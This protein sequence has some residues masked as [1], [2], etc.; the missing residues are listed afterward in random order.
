MNPQDVL[1]AAAF[2]YQDLQTSQ[3]HH[4]YNMKQIHLHKRD[5]IQVNLVNTV[6]KLIHI[7]VLKI[8]TSIDGP[9]HVVKDLITRHPDFTDDSFTENTKN[10]TAYSLV[11]NKV[12]KIPYNQIVGFEMYLGDKVFTSDV[13]RS[14][15]TS[16][17]W[18]NHKTWCDKQKQILKSRISRISGHFD[19]IITNIKNAESQGFEKVDA[20]VINTEIMIFKNVM[21]MPSKLKDALPDDIQSVSINTFVKKLEQYKVHYATREFY[22]EQYGVKIQLPQ[23]F[24]TQEFITEYKRIIGVYIAK[25]QRDMDRE[26]KQAKADNDEDS[27]EEIKAIKQMLLEVVDSIDKEPAQLVDW[28]PPIILPAPALVSEYFKQLA[29]SLA[30]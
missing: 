5:D 17:N 23:E 1:G 6:L 4:D 16:E 3:D 27:I 10:F 21:S 14:G 22:K 28:W 19:R 24:D 13:L 15:F 2:L 18:E 8:K 25:Y 30:K 9:D 20:N 12:V 26:L 11:L 7:G 29:L